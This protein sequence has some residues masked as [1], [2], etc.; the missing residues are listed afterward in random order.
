MARFVFLLA[1]ASL[2]SL[3]ATYS[4]YAMPI[5]FRMQAYD[6]YSL[7]KEPVLSRDGEQ[8]F[9]QL[10]FEAPPGC[11]SSSNACTNHPEYPEV[12]GTYQ[13]IWES[14]LQKTSLKKVIYQ[15]DAKYA[16][17]LKPVLPGEVI[18]WA[19]LDEDQRMRLRNYLVKVSGPK[20]GLKRLDYFKKMSDEILW[21]EQQHVKHGILFNEAVQQ[22]MNSPLIPQL[23]PQNML[24]TASDKLDET[25]LQRL[26]VQDREKRVRK[27]LE[28][29]DV[30][31]SRFHSFLALPKSY[32]VL[33]EDCACHGGK[34]CEEP[35]PAF[36]PPDFICEF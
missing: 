36:P 11:T 31:S 21:H 6:R 15:L 9:H 2:F 25:T 19:P 29:T 16:A 22:I 14:P 12:E 7:S 27:A 34:S 18:V 33:V 32:P 1:W 17:G 24:A 10:C 26:I 5:P 13:F 3:G 23:A 30:C 28:M 4:A 8:I 20:E 35:L